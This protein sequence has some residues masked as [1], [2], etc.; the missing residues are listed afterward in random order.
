MSVTPDILR[1]VHQHSE[2]KQVI[3]LLTVLH[4]LFIQRSFTYMTSHELDDNA[5]DTGHAVPVLEIKNL[6]WREANRI[7]QDYTQ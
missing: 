5:V 3:P 2:D 7:V 4:T 1:S 6:R